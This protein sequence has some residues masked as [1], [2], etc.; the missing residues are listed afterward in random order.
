MIWFF[1]L[2]SAVFWGGTVIL[3]MAGNRG[4]CV[5]VLSMP[6]TVNGERMRREWRGKRGKGYGQNDPGNL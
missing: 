1:I 5:P 6:E 2:E 3:A 4:R